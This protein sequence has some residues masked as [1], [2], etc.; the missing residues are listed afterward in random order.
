VKIG[1]ISDTHLSS[2]DEEFRRM[3]E[4]YFS[5]VDYIIHAGDSVDRCVVAFF[6]DWAE[7]NHKKFVI[8]SGNMDRGGIVGELPRKQV[9]SIQGKKIG[10]I[11]GWGAPDGLEERVMEE[12]DDVDCIVYGHTHRAV[13]TTVGDVLLFNP[14]SPTDRR[15]AKK[16]TIGFLHIDNDDIRGEILNI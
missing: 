10:V 1:V 6:T 11:H 7:E 13:N 12:F 4:H 9:V 16:N 14:G 8:V 5:D 2:V 3:I 15:F